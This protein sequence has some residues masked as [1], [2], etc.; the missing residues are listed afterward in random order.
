MTTLESIKEKIESIKKQKEELVNQL[1]ND[2]APMLKPLFDKTN[3]KITS[4]GWNQYTPYFNDGDECMFSVNFDYLNINGKNEYD[5]DSLDWRIKYYLEG[6]E[7]YPLQEE[8]D[9]ELFGFVNEFKELLN[10]IDDDFYKDLF[11]DHVEVTV[12]ADG[13]VET[14]EYDHD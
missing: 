7:K 14:S 2:F 4:I 5:I 8:W 1:K 3:G 11:G 13:T 9:L 12:N 10:S 6:N